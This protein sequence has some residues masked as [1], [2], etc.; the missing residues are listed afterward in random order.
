MGIAARSKGPSFSPIS[1]NTGHMPVSPANQNLLQRQPRLAES[2]CL[3]VL[4]HVATR[5]KLKVEW[6][7]GSKLF[8]KK[9]CPQDAGC[10]PLCWP[11]GFLAVYL[12]ED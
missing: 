10:W 6:W 7:T 4:R 12:P 9:E 1:L 5:I 3:C 8:A 11:S 2:S